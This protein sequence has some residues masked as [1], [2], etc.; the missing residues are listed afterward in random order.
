VSPHS[1]LLHTK[2]FQLILDK[3]HIGPEKFI[4]KKEMRWTEKPASTPILILIKPEDFK[5]H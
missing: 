2:P 5:C 1:D 4:E 3:L